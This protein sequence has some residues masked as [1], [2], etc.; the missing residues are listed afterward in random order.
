MTAKTKYIVKMVGVMILILAAPALFFSSVGDTPLTLQSGEKRQI[1]LV[2]ED[3]G[4]EKEEQQLAF[5]QEMASLL[6]EESAFEWT[7]ESRSAAENGLKKNQYDAVVYIPSEFSANIMTYEEE[8]PLKAEFRYSLQDQLNTVNRERV[9]REIEASTAKVNSSI[10]TLY[11]SYIAQDLEGVRSNFDDILEKELEFQETIAASYVPT[12]QA[13][14]EDMAQQRSELENIRASLQSNEEMGSGSIESAGQFEESLGQFVEN[15]NQY[16]EYQLNQNELLQTLQE[17]NLTIVTGVMNLNDSRYEE[18]KTG[19]LERNELF[20]ESFGLLDAQL[21]ENNE[22]MDE[23]S[24]VRVEEVIRQKNDMIEYKMNEEEKRQDQLISSMTQLKAKLANLPEEEQELPE[25]PAGEPAQEADPEANPPINMAAI[26]EKRVQ[27]AEVAAEVEK[28]NQSLSQVATAEEGQLTEAI[29]ALS[30]LTARIQQVEKELSSAEEQ[31]A[32]AAGMQTQVAALQEQLAEAQNSRD[33]LSEQ[34]YSYS[35]FD[36]ITGDVEQKED[37]I[38]K[39]DLLTSEQKEILEE[40]FDH[41][42]SNTQSDLLINYHSELVQFQ[43]ALQT[44]LKD[45]QNYKTYEENIDSILNITSEEQAL[46]D[47]LS[48]KVPEANDQFAL[49]KDEVS[50]FFENYSED[51]E[52]QQSLVEAELSAI[53]ETAG[54]VMNQI[55]T[56]SNEAPVQA[57]GPSSGEAM[58]AGQ[59]SITDGLARMNEAISQIGDSQSSVISYTNEL[60]GKVQSIK[61][62]AENLNNKWTQNIAAT[63]LYHD[64]IFQLLGNSFVDGQKN[65]QVY[66]HLA[67]PLQMN[68]GVAAAQSEEQKIPPVVV[69][70]IV[71]ISSLLIGF[72]SSYFEK[73]AILIKTSIFILLN[74]VVGLIISI[75]GLELYPLNEQSAIQWSV[76]TILL[77]IASSAIVLS[78]FSIGKLA[79]SL[80]TVGLVVLF[81]IPLLTV[82]VPSFNYED[83]M[84]KV[85]M[86]IQ[87]GPD[88]LFTGA[89]FTLLGILAAAISLPFVVKKVRSSKG[90][91]QE[92]ETYEAS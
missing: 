57:I 11:W 37:H 31:L 9:L 66:S 23:L 6:S 40:S 85:Y 64:D 65:S 86:S 49:L 4:V 1:A 26:A 80:A 84:S 45:E 42:I 13:L 70:V 43:A 63:K 73:A 51:V 18:I 32:A 30:N 78:A 34:I 52:T 5:G 16:R 44:S 46:F 22:T 41:P 61:T 76:F 72:F 15:V 54:D 81:V 29:T 82:S 75:Y 92:E 14:A 39:S 27:L 25:I 67:S 47:E 89:V 88:S 58:A 69:I 91:Q 53:Q 62:D 56:I 79:G 28:V 36:P 50:L 59:Q 8:N 87:Y 38:L 33:A 19:L 20:T 83:P 35:Q 12:S 77:L 2:N 68:S 55:L 71:L 74:L 21:L 24:I 60:Q 7:V 17:D 48:E 10:S 3:I 90:T